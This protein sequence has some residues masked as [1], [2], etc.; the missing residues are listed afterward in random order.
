MLFRSALYT[1][2]YESVVNDQT[3]NV[4]TSVHITFAQKWLTGSGTVGTDMVA[5]ATR[6]G[7]EYTEGTITDT[8]ATLATDYKYY[9]ATVDVSGQAAGTD[10]Q[11]RLR[12]K[13]T[14]QSAFFVLSAFALDS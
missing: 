7:L 1:G 5:E 14:G 9:E 3:G 13:N 2:F 6:N 10:I 12:D 8:S 4:I 11:V